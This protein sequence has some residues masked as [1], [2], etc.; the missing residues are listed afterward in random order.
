MLQRFNRLTAKLLPI[1]LKY[2]VIITY[3]LKYYVLGKGIIELCSDS[4]N[5]Y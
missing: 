1:S 4:K 2:H 5:H 3:L